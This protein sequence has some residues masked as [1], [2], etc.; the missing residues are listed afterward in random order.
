MKGRIV[1]NGNIQLEQDFIHSFRESLQDA[2]HQDA[3]VR[4]SRKTLLIT[5]AWQKNEHDEQHVRDALHG[6]GLDHVEN[7]SLYH[8]FNQLRSA[9]PDL[10]QVYH[11]KQKVVKQVKLFYREKNSGLIRILQNQLR[12]LRETFPHISL[13][14]VLAYNVHSGQQTLAEYNPWQMLYHYACQDIQASIEKLREHDEHMLQVCHEIDDTF[15]ASSGVLQHPLYQQMRA[16]MTE[17]L[18]SANSI[19]IFGGHIAVLFNRLNFFRLKDVF[20]EALERGTNFYTV[21]AG[22]MSLCDYLVVFDEDSNE[23]TRSAR[24]ADFELFDKGFGL[25]K[26]VQ[27]FPHC[28]DY[29]A[30]EDPDTV[31][32]TA[33]RFNRSLCVGLDQRS[34]LQMETYRHDGREYERFVSVGAREGLYLL[35]ANGEVEVKHAGEELVVPGTQAWERQHG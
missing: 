4:D 26:K 33:A 9:D 32:Y 14:Q 23:W 19:F 21:S 12:L 31:A 3:A 17:R 34:F 6:I 11:T 20:L 8:S 35:H 13:A 18:L 29:I 10:Y 27:L 28:K 2:Q 30:M 1:F 25:V 15:F 5:A 7:L 24:M 16:Q 22:S